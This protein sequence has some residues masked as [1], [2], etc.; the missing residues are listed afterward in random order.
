MQFKQWF[1]KLWR[2][3]SKSHSA[4]QQLL[5]TCCGGKTGE[6]KGAAKKAKR[7]RRERTSAE[8]VL[9]SYA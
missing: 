8:S 3:T 2:A 6:K 9:N 4:E 1:R 7:A 5:D